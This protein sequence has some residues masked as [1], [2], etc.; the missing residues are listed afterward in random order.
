MLENR[1]E[2]VAGES[3][4]AE[5]TTEKDDSTFVNDSASEH[6]SVMPRM[7]RSKA[8]RQAAALIY[9]SQAAPAKQS[10]NLITGHFQPAKMIDGK[11][12]EE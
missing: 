9:P 1:L 7:T 6:G 4:T 2:E 5:G 8:A 10:K 12:K 11:K 3:I